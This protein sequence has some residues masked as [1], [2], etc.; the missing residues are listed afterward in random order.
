VLKWY[1]ILECIICSSA[2][3]EIDADVILNIYL[4]RCGEER[5]K[6]NARLEDGAK[7]ECSKINNPPTKSYYFT[8]EQTP[9]YNECFQSLISVFIQDKKEGERAKEEER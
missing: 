5:K 1:L 8:V 3:Y 6:R 4:C 7:F 2:W 9:T